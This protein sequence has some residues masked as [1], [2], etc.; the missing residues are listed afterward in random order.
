VPYEKGFN[1]LYYLQSICGKDKFKAILRSYIQKFRLQSIEYT[2]WK[3]HF[4]SHV[5]SLFDK[6]TAKSILDKVDWDTWIF[7]PGFPVVEN[8]F[9]NTFSTEAKSR[10]DDIFAQQPKEDFPALFNNWHTSVKLVFLN[11]IAKNLDKFTDNNYVYLRDTLKLHTDFNMEIKNV[12]YQIALNSKH[13]DV[14][15]YAVDFL[16]KIGRMKYVRP[17]YKSFA[18]V[19]RALAYETFLKFK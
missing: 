15:P 16:G 6:D 19:D 17:L 3:D 4:I 18:L 8:D 12:W 10:L 13:R 2:D 1:F 9:S 14:I 7:T 11:M 5:N